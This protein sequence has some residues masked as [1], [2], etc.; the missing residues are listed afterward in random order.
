[1]DHGEDGGCFLSDYEIDRIGKAVQQSSPSSMPHFRKLKRVASHS[2]EDMFQLVY[3]LSPEPKS[4]PF[5][6]SPDRANVRSSEPPNDEAIHRPFRESSAR[7]SARKS[8]QRTPS[9][10]S[11]S[12]SANR[13]S[14][15]SR[16][17]SGMGTSSGFAA[18]ASQSA[19]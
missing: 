16:C 9:S 2:F 1:M 19:W 18:I 15:I 7:S 13:S 10:G 12:N 3:E 17:Q 14:R 5:G 11:L 8:S 6:P 4:F